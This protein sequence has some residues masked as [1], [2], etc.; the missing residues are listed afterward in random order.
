MNYNP[1]KDDCEWFDFDSMCKNERNV[2]FVKDFS[3][4]HYASGDTLLS[5]V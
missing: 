4:F 1:H 3:N 5:V 2:Y